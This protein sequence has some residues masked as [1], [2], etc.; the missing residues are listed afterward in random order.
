MREESADAAWV[1]REVMKQ[2]M[3]PFEGD[4]RGMLGALRA[5]QS[6]V[7]PV[8]IA[9]RL[10][11][12]QAPVHLLIGDKPSGAAPTAAQIILLR[13]RLSSFR[14][15]TIARSGIMLQEEQPDA[16]ISEVLAM[17]RRPQA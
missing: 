3:E 13:E 10:R 6:A 16:V 14:L 17:L 4:L 9:D 1:T 11:A 15:D 7:E 5:M 2:Y 8:L 12:I